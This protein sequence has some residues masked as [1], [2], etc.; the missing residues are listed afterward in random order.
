M[1]AAA[2]YE[3]AMHYLRSVL[4]CAR[5]GSSYDVRADAVVCARCGASY[6]V[7]DGVPVLLNDTTVGT[8]L[9]EID[10]TEKQIDDAATKWEEIIDTIGLGAPAAMEIGAGTGT[11]TLALRRTSVVS[12]LVATDVSVQFLRELR[13]RVG[14]DPAVSVIVCDSNERHFQPEVFDLV[15]GRSILHHLLDYED[16]LRNCCD[17]LRPGGAA[18]F[19][20]PVLEGKTTV[21][22]LVALMLRCDEEIA[23]HVFTEAER[24][25][26]RGLVRHLIK[27]KLGLDRETLAQYEDKYIFGIEEMREVGRRV[28]FAE[29]EFRNNGDVKPAYW[30]YVAKTCQLL[31]IATEKVDRYRWIGVQYAA[32]YALMFPERLVT[33]MGFFIFRK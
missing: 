16:T 29:V 31:G 4:R 19:F 6:P 24:N 7:V 26:L 30:G 15:V 8:Q 2:A 1:D 14:D 12:R 20:E 33:P 17:M 27:S 9:D 3:A 32:T 13:L 23:G 18:V 11:L 10:L 5:C 25:K 21:A 22:L 28:G